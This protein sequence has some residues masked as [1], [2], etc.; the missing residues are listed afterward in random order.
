MHRRAVASF[1]LDAPES[2]LTSVI[3]IDGP[4]SLLARLFSPSTFFKL[5][6]FYW[7]SLIIWALITSVSYLH[8]VAA[9]PS[10]RPPPPLRPPPLPSINGI[11]NRTYGSFSTIYLCSFNSKVKGRIEISVLAMKIINIFFNN[12][13][14]TQFLNFSQLAVARYAAFPKTCLMQFQEDTRYI[15]QGSGCGS[16]WWFPLQ[17]EGQTVRPG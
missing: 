14:V 1:V 3:R 4:E 10:L 8:S 2:F 9:C 7:S 16:T 11:I 12:S 5:S 15:T 13:T 6:R 17:P